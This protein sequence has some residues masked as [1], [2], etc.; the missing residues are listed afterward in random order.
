MQTE[1]CIVLFNYYAKKKHY[2]LFLKLKL[3]TCGNY[4]F[5]CGIICGS[6]QTETSL[7]YFY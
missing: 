1:I 4:T 3:G 5:E 2:S 6:L 7:I